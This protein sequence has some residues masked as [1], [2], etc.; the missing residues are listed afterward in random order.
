M[1]ATKS[2]VLIMFCRSTNSYRA[3]SY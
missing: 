1:K 3:F 2:A